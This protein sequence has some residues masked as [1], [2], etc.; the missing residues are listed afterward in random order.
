VLI[1]VK[2]GAFVNDARNQMNK[3]QA[4]TFDED[5]AVLYLKGYCTASHLSVDKNITVYTD[6]TPRKNNKN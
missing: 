4:F 5:I 6:T 1:S 2:C 3:T